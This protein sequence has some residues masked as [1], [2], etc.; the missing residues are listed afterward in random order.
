MKQKNYLVSN[1]TVKISKTR[2]PCLAQGVSRETE[3]LS[4]FKCYS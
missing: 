2:T 4:G 1:A 3:E